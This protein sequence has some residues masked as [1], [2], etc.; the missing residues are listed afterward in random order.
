MA[1]EDETR[2]A[3]ERQRERAEHAEHI[4]ESVDPD[5]DEHSYPVRTEELA[6]EYRGSEFDL[7]NETESWGSVFDRLRDEY[8]EFETADQARDAML[9]E[10]GRARGY[11]EDFT[12]EPQATNPDAP[13]PGTVEGE[14]LADG[15]TAERAEE[16]VH[17][18]ED[19]EREEEERADRDPERETE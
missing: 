10:V 18:P 6:A 13:A 3:R 5:L 1:N 17:V 4:L 12:D 2:A 14:G 15:A 19:A 8:D 7:A 11:D 16:G 9:D